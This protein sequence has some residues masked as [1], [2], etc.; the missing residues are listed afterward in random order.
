MTLAQVVALT[1]RKPVPVERVCTRLGLS[2][3]RLR[4]M[5]KQADRDGYHVKMVNGHVSCR[6]PMG[7]IEPV[8]IGAASPG[9]RVHV[10][11]LTDLHVGSA[12]CAEDGVRDILHRAWDKGARACVGTGDLI[13][14]TGPKAVKLLAD[15]RCATWDGQTDRVVELFREVPLEHAWIDGNHDGYSSDAAGMQSGRQLQWK[16]RDAGLKWTFLGMCAG[17]AT[18]AGARFFLWHPHGAGTTRN[19]VRRSVNAKIE[20]LDEPTDFVCS[21]HFHRAAIVPAFGERVWGLAGGTAQ[22]RASEFANRATAGW[23][24]GA[25]LISFSMDKTGAV[26]EP[27]A[28]WL[29]IKPKY[30]RIAA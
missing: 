10:L 26:H 17:R 22:I 3:S 27:S 25:W 12:H 20:A 28:E 18:V 15:Q 29:E 30:L 6:V 14:G 23:D 8:V 7:A 1:C 13:D 5:L 11:H 16:A 4:L 2:E 24:M 19:S 9:K 21:G